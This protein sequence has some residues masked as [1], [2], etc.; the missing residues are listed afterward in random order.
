MP[1]EELTHEGVSVITCT[2]NE[3]YRTRI[4]VN[5]LTQSWP[6]KELIIILNQDAMN[7]VEWQ[8][9]VQDHPNIRVYQLPES[10]TLGTCLNYGVSLA[11]YNYVAKFDHDDYYSPKF[12]AEAMEAFNRT[13]ADVVGKRTYFMYFTKGKELRLRFPGREH[14]PTKLVHGSTIVVKKQVLQELPF[15]DIPLGEEIYFF[16]SCREKGYKIFSTSRYNYAYLRRSNKLHAWKAKK[17]Y[18]LRTS[19]RI[20]ITA[21]YKKYTDL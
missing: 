6:N 14:R 7:L 4:L 13:N 3:R 21:K 17:D 8:N 19:R 5:F 11:G 1:E 16:R 12:L 9:N 10:C 15:I 20:A 18:L 2:N